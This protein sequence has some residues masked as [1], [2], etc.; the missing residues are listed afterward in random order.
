[1]DKVKKIKYREG[2]LF[3]IPIK[4]KGYYIGI[5][6][7]CSPKSPTC[8]GFFF[9]KKFISL[10]GLDQ[11]HQKAKEA[12][13]IAWFGD[14][15]LIIGDWPIIGPINNFQ[16]E[17]WPVPLFKRIDLLDPS[18]GWIV[19]YPQTAPV[20]TRSIGETRVEA[21]S[22]EGLVEDELYGSKA[23]E[24]TLAKLNKK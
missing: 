20:F 13:L 8:L 3:G 16:A 18:F 5:V 12:I 6:A 17:E 24:I 4:P 10:P 19:E 22:L 23:L 14:L 15:G 9:G 1:V 21:S 7:R 11:V 2:D